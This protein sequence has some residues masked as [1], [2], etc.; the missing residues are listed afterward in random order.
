M[1]ETSRME[2]ASND[3]DANLEIQETKFLNF[4]NFS[5][6]Y[7]T[8]SNKI[9]ETVGASAKVPL[10]ESDLEYFNAFP[11]FQTFMKSQNDRILTLMTQV[12]KNQNVKKSN[13]NSNKLDD[14]E[15]IDL[16]ID[17]NDQLIEKLGI[18]LD[19]IQGLRKKT[20]TELKLS[21]TTLN[22]TSRNINTSWNKDAGMVI[23]KELAKNLQTTL[24][25]NQTTSSGMEHTQF[26]M[27]KG[28]IQKSQILFED[29][30]DNSSLPFL[31]KIKYKPNA[32]KPL[33][34]IFNLI[35]NDNFEINAEVF[36]EN[37]ELL[38]NPY[39]H[40]I[41]QLTLTEDDLKPLSE[42]Q[43]IPIEKANYKFIDNPDDLKWLCE[44]LG[45]ENRSKIKEISV[46]LEHHSY[47]SFLGFTCLM[48]ISTHD[49][50]FL[51]D[52]LKL[53]SDM[54]LLNEVF[55]DWTLL[56]V[57]HGSDFDIE[58]LQKDFGIYIVN[59]FDTGQAAR[60]LN[61]P[62]FSL[63]YLLQK[64]CNVTAQKQYQLAD[65]RVRPLS[66]GMVKYAREDT[67]YLLY[68]YDKLKNELVNQ[69]HA[70]MDLNQTSL[71]QV[72]E[73]CKI[74]CKKTYK[75]PVFYTK[76]FLT[77]CQN[78]SHLNSKQ[79][80]ALQ[81]LYKWRDRMAREH[82]ESYEFVLKNHQLLKI[83]E[84]LPREIYGILALCNPV[85]PL[86]ETNVHEIHEI[87]K[88]AREFT[89]TM[90]ALD[91]GGQTEDVIGKIESGPKIE[92]IAHTVTF[93]PD[94]ILNCP[95]DFPHLKNE[96]METEQLQD[97]NA[98]ETAFKSNLGDLLMRPG[99]VQTTQLPDNFAQKE[100]ILMGKFFDK[101]VLGEKMD[102]RLR[103]IEEKV[104]E[105]KK[106]IRNP[107]ELYLPK[108]YQIMGHRVEPEKYWNLLKST[109]KMSQV[110]SEEEMDEKVQETKTEDI[111][112]IPL[113]KQFKLEKNTESKKLKKRLKDVDFSD[114][115]IEYNKM[116]SESVQALGGEET[117]TQNDQHFNNLSEKVKDNLKSISEFVKKANFSKNFTE[118]AG[119]FSGYSAENLNQMFSKSHNE[120]QQEQKQKRFEDKFGKVNKRRA[121]NAVTRSKNNK[122]FTFKNNSQ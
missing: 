68:I 58:W 89:G 17:I 5:Q 111:L 101:N 91:I 70:D 98:I 24:N 34:D 106:E 112:M 65:W 93:D 82:D 10:K 48:Q 61:Y 113:K 73:K 69:S 3:Q 117:E 35:R 84:L 88:K 18:Q 20:E 7:D 47:R 14:E 116:K 12:L 37:I 103:K 49:Y 40:E 63:S 33:P 96:P 46:D 78:N 119:E 23:N 53:R 76:G 60:Q 29:K 19:E 41:E 86:V 56:K 109:E 36:Q 79:M 38:E 62:H 90:T 95:H 21:S 44:Y 64:F 105:I 55:T 16:L 108:Y 26:S 115:I 80:K 31:P 15:R 83:A 104:N 114:A 28:Q 67:R 85:S 102:K 52:T 54:H 42:R 30:I 118:N 74:L 43:L 50:D 6:F 72:Y 27:K 57:L 97:E 9:K 77:L 11:S 110:E 120:Q 45:K 94:S 4:D 87:I 81:D 92:S 25:R 51:I 100:T 122:S 13:F 59:M 99:G 8:F 32:L 1:S 39:T 121:T 75:K 22:V 2:V 107:F 66:E 71:Y